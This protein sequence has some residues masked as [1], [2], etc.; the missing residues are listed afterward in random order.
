VTHVRM[1]AHATTSQPAW[2]LVRLAPSPC[3]PA[4]DDPA[5]APCSCA[6]AGA[7]AVL[8]DRLQQA[9]AA[10]A[11]CGA[12]VARPPVWALRVQVPAEYQGGGPILGSEGRWLSGVGC[13]L[14]A[15][16]CC[17][18]AWSAGDCGGTGYGPRTVPVR[19]CCEALCGAGLRR[20]G[21]WPGFAKPEWTKVI[22]LCCSVCQQ[23]RMGHRGGITSVGLVG[24]H[25]AVCKS[26][27]CL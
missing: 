3:G 23:S 21:W 22:R 1:E 11:R 19:D 12:A 14:A 27:A 18:A 20:D 6:R 13:M 9:R 16:C 15:L 2:S 25:T 17:F 10:D 8:H 24:G 7:H 5:F 4:R 26:G